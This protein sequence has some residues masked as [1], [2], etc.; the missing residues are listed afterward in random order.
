MKTT[1]IHVAKAE[2]QRRRSWLILLV[3]I[4]WPLAAMAT[5]QSVITV[6]EGTHE[7]VRHGM[8]IGRIAVG[9]PA[10]ADVKVINRRDLL[11]TGKRRGITS[12]KVWTEGERRSTESRIV[13]R[14]IT[15][16]D[17]QSG[18]PGQAKA[19][20]RV[21]PGVG[22]TGKADDLMGHHAGHQ[23]MQTERQAIDTSEVPGRMQ[24]QADIRV[25]EVNR[26]SLRQHGFNFLKNDVGSTLAVS[27]PSA[28]SGISA[29][30]GGTP[31][32]LQSTSGFLPLQE[33]FN[34]VFGDSTD[35]VL[36]VLSLLEQQ[37]LVRTL[38]EPSLTVM[39]GQT[40]TFLAGGEF[41]IPVTQGGG[42][43][44]NTNITIEFKEFG[45][46]LNLTPT[47]LSS[48]RLVLKVAP[49]VSELDFSAGIQTAGVSVPALSIRRTDTTIELG[50]GESFVISGLVSQNMI[51]NVDKVPFLGSLPILGAFFKSTRYSRE[52][53]ELI[54]VVTPH[55][56]RPLAREA[57]LPSLPGSRYDD[58]DPSA[59]YLMGLEAG[60]FQSDSF[61]FSR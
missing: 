8:P 13:V 29:P 23:A 14:P 10:V 52:D 16:P 24:V 33:A 5:H 38:A 60:D 17:S 19:D 32:T 53:K 28:L 27:P 61:G 36:A 40:A 57:A 21:V 44:G 56:V 6:E 11:I 45:V 25:V 43:G 4:A 31:F 48:E 42:G 7:Q 26:R 30:G 9:D 49:E 1:A 3:L 15:N 22:L 58:Y 35:N 59:G 34:L 20:M 12:L 55:L 46:R 54:M 51:A 47:V 37:G 2:R 39:S 50:D 41:P 18:I